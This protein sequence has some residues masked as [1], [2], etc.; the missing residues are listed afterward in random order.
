MKELLAYSVLKHASSYLLDGNQIRKENFVR[1]ANAIKLAMELTILAQQEGLLFLE[2]WGNEYT[3]EN[4]K[5]QDFVKVLILSIVDGID[6]DEVETMAMNQII[7]MNPECF[8]SYLCYLFM[9]ALTGVQCALSPYLVEKRLLSCVP[10]LIKKRLVEIL[11]HCYST[12]S[13]KKIVEDANNWD[14]MDTKEACEKDIPLIRAFETKIRA[15]NSQSIARVLREVEFNKI[16]IVL[17][18]CKRD[19]R[20]KISRML[21]KQIKARIYEDLFYTS[22]WKLKESLENV[23]TIINKLE[24][25]GYITKDS[26][27]GD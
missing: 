17:A 6:P 2:E 19:V 15:F 5:E 3:G 1:V 12:L 24:E 9:L 26:I 23:L 11:P 18:F 21:T 25:R 13:E 10:Y 4:Q 14:T 20:M 27:Y 22:K 16:G 8:E 7:V